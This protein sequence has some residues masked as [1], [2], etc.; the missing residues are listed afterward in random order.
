MASVVNDPGGRKR[1]SYKVEAKRYSL[2]LGEVPT[3]I[4][5]DA[6]DK[7]TRLIAC[8]NAAHL[9][10]ID[11]IE[12]AAKL[13]AKQY[14]QLADAK[15]LPEREEDRQERIV[16]LN[17]FLTEAFAA[18]R[19]KD[20]TMVIYGNCRRCLLLHFGKERDV[21]TITHRDADAFHTW[22]STHEFQWKKNKKRRL[23]QVTVARRLLMS[24]H[25]FN[26]AVRWKYLAENPFTGIKVARQV[27]PARKGYV[28]V[29]SVQIVI[30]AS[31]NAQF[32]L[33]LA[34]CRFA[35]LRCPSEHIALRWDEVDWGHGRMTVHS[36]KTEHHPGGEC[37]VIPIFTDLRPYLEAAFEAAPEGAEFVI[38]EWRSEKK[39]LRTRFQKAIA[40]AGIKPWPKLFQNLR[41][42]FETDLVREYPIPT[43]A[44]WLGHDPA[45]MVKNYL[46]N[47]DLNA[48]FQ[49]ASENKLT[50]I[51]TRKASKNE[52]K[53]ENDGWGKNTKTPEIV[54]LSGVPGSVFMGAA[55]REPGAI[56]RLKT[57]PAESDAH[58]DALDPDLAR[59]V[60]LWGG[61]SAETRAAIARLA[62]VVRDT[63]GQA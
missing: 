46:T 53:S 1:I 55:G 58:S 9:L 57:T 59:I 44:E 43:V 60:E 45:V 15:L 48:D 54:A 51:P 47:P 21:R 29:D 36:P 7:I 34:L 37:R 3:A 5:V 38:R 41:A 33:I 50:R 32:N 13:P 6:C 12:W 18:L 11:V 52:R 8:R 27:N 14:R 23:S 10:S 17:E 56:S 30:D 39:N 40:R 4:A 26:R 42:S 24:R 31:A 25:I 62:G 63:G 28:P 35:G 49:R 22:L 19:V 2:R 20:S 16:T 61:L